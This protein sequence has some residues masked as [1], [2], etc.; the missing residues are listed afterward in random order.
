M[1][2][3]SRY[4]VPDIVESD[5]ARIDLSYRSLRYWMTGFETAKRWFHEEWDGS[6]IQLDLARDIAKAIEVEVARI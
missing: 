3:K 1:T 6:Y 4:D 5:D 2:E